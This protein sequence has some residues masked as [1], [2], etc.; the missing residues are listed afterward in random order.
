MSGVQTTGWTK[1]L[2]FAILA[3]IP[4][5]PAIRDASFCVTYADLTTTW[6]GSQFVPSAFPVH[7][8]GGCDLVQPG[9]PEWVIGENVPG[10]VVIT[11]HAETGFVWLPLAS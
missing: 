9:N 2:L 3:A 4:L 10:S 1:R 5:C 11:R 8:P 7:L 6:S